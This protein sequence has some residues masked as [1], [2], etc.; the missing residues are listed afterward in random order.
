[1]LITKKIFKKRKEGKEGL[2]GE[3]RKE[4]ASKH[5]PERKDV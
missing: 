4:E 3:R 5:G 1:M 2:K